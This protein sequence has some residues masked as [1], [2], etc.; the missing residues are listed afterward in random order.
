MSSPEH[1]TIF[2]QLSAEQRAAFAEP[3][4]LTELEI[5]AA[6]ERERLAKIN[7]SYLQFISAPAENN[8]LTMAIKDLGNCAYLY[9]I[10]PDD[11]SA[12]EKLLTVAEEAAERFE[13][14][15]AAIR[16]Y[17]PVLEVQP[18]HTDTKVGQA[19][20]WGHRGVTFGITSHQGFR[21][22]NTHGV[23]LEAYVNGLHLS[24]VSLSGRELHVYTAIDSTEAEALTK[25][26]GVTGEIAQA[27][28]YI[29]AS[30]IVGFLDTSRT[31]FP[32][33]FDSSALERELYGTRAEHQSPTDETV[34][35]PIDDL[36]SELV[37]RGIIATSKR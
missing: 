29:G 20:R 22:I 5:Q 2:S 4:A 11:P 10:D 36:V 9:D 3:L 15:E 31:L 28:T 13:A 32:N 21:S 8:L 17:T 1:A 27:A 37:T 24:S 34:T 14:I 26:P 16:P 12:R 25:A 19:Y 23:S 33:E 18:W 6:I 30:A 35:K 7:R